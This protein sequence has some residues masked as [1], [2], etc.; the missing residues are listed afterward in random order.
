MR[1]RTFAC[2]L[3][4]LMAFTLAC[5]STPAGPTSPSTVNGGGDAPALPD[6]STLKVTAPTAVSPVGGVEVTD[7]D[8]DL[9]ITNSTATFFPGALSLS[10]VFEVIGEDGRVVYTSAAIPQGGGGQTRHE[11]ARDLNANEVHDWR[12]YAV[13]QGRQGPKSA[14]ATFKTFDRFGVSCA[15]MGSELAIVAC[16]QAQYD[17]IPHDKLPEFLARVAHDLNRGGFEHAPYGRLVKTIGNNCQGYSCDIICSNR[18]L[19]RQW[20]VLVDEDAAQIPAWNRVG[21]PAQRPCQAV[22]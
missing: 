11:I 14:N 16:R 22:D 7:L 17:H 10:Y 19:H 3:A 15:H 8:P 12:A 1:N 20:D 18:G 4:A 6:G 21:G 5:N 9:V 13:F 2:G